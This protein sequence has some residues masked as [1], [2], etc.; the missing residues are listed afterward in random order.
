MIYCPKCEGKGSFP[1]S[2][3][4]SLQGT[5]LFAILYGLRF[6]IPVHLY[7]HVEMVSFP[8][9]TFFL[10]KLSTSCIYFH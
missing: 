1:K 2:Q 9:H 10:G 4:K 7:G 6:Y 5:S 3:I 8:N